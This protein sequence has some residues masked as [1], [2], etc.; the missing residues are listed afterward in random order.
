MTK[1]PRLDATLCF[2]NEDR[3]EE[4]EEEKTEKEIEKEKNDK[5]KNEKEKNDKD[6]IK[7]IID[8]ND[9]EDEEDDDDD[10]GDEGAWDNGDIGEWKMHMILSHMLLLLLGTR[11]FFNLFITASP[12]FLRLLLQLMLLLLF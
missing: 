10:D 5:I 1:I 4:T 8:D 11:S 3:E 2:V 6:K 7:N 9:D 12:F